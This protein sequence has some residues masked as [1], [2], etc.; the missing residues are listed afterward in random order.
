MELFETLIAHLRAAVTNPTTSQL[1]RTDR[2]ALEAILGRAEKRYAAWLSLNSI[3]TGPATEPEAPET[4]SPETLKLWAERAAEDAERTAKEARSANY[5][6]EIASETANI[7]AEL[8][9]NPG[10]AASL[11]NMYE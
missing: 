5:Q 10:L 8:A 7:M 9:A 6:A 11:L 2:A 4:P 1:S 3:T